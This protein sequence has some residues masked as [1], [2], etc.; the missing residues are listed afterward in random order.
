MPLRDGRHGR[1]SRQHAS[2][3]GPSNAKLCGLAAILVALLAGGGWLYWKSQSLKVEV[4][5]ITLCPKETAPSE[6][7][8]ILLDLSDRL[9]EPQ[10]LQLNNE[11]DRIRDSVPKWGR[12]EVYVVG[13]DQKDV[14]SPTEP[15][16]NPGDGSDMDPRYQNPELAMKKWLDY[17]TRLAQTIDDRL[18]LPESSVSPIFEAIQ[19]TSLRTFGLPEFDA[20]AKRLVVA[21]DL[22]QNVPGPMSQYQGVPDFKAFT[23]SPYFS[24]IRADLDGVDVTL[25]YLERSDVPVQGPAHIEFWGQYFAAQGATVQIVKKIF[26]DQ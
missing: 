11:L 7:L 3:D 9:D 23:D 2:I 4:D 1:S 16:C 24:R 6:V 19:A 20:V 12:I 5:P 25:L 21:S 13:R 26:G 10:R 17:R 8:V 15:L 18:S 14:V 22:L